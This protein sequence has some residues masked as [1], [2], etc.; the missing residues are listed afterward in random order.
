MK[1]KYWNNSICTY[2]ETKEKFV[3]DK[4][5]CFKNTQNAMDEIYAIF[6][7]NGKNINE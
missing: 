5:L 7:K 4:W 3:Y 2:I 6:K 1:L